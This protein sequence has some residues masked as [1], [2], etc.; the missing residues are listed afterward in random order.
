MVKK[1]YGKMRGT[2]RK[3]RKKEKLP[4]NRFFSEFK[5]GDRVHIKIDPSS[6]FQTAKFHGKTGIVLGKRGRCYIIK[7][8]NGKSY[9]T[10]FLKPEHL[11]R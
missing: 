8:R 10:I 2:R 6:K 1:S 7:V 11:V 4:I 5:E 3:L 9:K